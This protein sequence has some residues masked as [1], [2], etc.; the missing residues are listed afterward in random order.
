M[1]S[2]DLS[3]SVFS[4]I[5]QSFH[6]DTYRDVFQVLTDDLDVMMN[7]SHRAWLPK[8]WA[9]VAD[10]GTVFRNMMVRSETKVD[11]LKL[12]VPVHA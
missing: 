1:P 7:S 12:T 2:W 3:G 4:R 6:A 9:K 11:H 8:T 5:E 10:Q